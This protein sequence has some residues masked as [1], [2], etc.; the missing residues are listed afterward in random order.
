[1]HITF[2]VFFIIYIFSSAVTRM[3]NTRKTIADLQQQPLEG[4]A[5]VPARQAGVAERLGRGQAQLKQPAVVLQRPRAATEQLH[6]G[7]E[8]LRGNSAWEQE[9][10]KRGSGME[11][12]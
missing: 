10:Q 8:L 2:T 11:S 3:N 4:Q 9:K 5:S 12:K 7:A 1:M 6:V